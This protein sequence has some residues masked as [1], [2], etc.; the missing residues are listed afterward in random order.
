MP[1]KAGSP[2]V[3]QI[4]KV[5][6]KGYVL[7]QPSRTARMTGSPQN[8]RTLAWVMPRGKYVRVMFVADV[9]DA[10]KTLLKNTT[11]AKGRVVVNVTEDKVDQA[12]SLIAWAIEKAPRKRPPRAASRRP[13]RSSRSSRKPRVEKRVHFRLAA[14]GVRRR[15]TGPTSLSS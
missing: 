8:G 4:A 12:R 9:T 6:G 2:A 11:V 3:Q 14:G 13:S 10:P 7:T 15:S 1:A 5:I